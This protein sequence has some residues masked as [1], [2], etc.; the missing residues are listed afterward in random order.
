V[1]VSGGLLAGA[2]VVVTGAGSGL[3]RAYSVALAEAGASVLANDLDER[4]LAGTV[5]I[6]RAG[7]GSVRGHVRAVG[8]REDA[9]RIIAAC[10]DSFGSLDGLVANAGVLNPGASRTLSES[11]VE[12]TL[13]TNVAGVWH[14][15]AAAMDVM[16]PQGSGSIVTVVSGAMAGLENLALYGTSKS[17]V[18]GMTY[19]LALELEGTGVR[20]NAVSPLANTA[21]SD[22]MDIDEAFKGGPPEAVA[23]VVVHL[24]SDR[25]RDLHGQVVRF[26]GRSLGLVQAPRLAATTAA[27]DAWTA[28]D[29]AEAL[30]GPL[31]SWRAPVGLVAAPPPTTV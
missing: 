15:C 2:S 13:R 27:R 14:C 4:G 17:A 12:A 22:D 20:I 26:D 11:T 16:V 19:G 1:A 25:S 29:V 7:G 18:L 5:E 24:M 3:G 8:G 21:M 10:I 23:P 9:E 30:D 6:I 31:R 28:D